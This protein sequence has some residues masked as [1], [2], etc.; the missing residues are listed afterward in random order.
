MSPLMLSLFFSSLATKKIRELGYD[1]PIFG[2][3]GNALQSDVDYFKECGANEV[4]AKPLDIELLNNL[5]NKT[6][7][8]VV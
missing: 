3:T 6:V 4:L 1:G 5:L 8:S 7:V 2:V